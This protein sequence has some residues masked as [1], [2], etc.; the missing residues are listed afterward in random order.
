MPP[1]GPTPTHRIRDRLEGLS[2]VHGLRVRPGVILSA[3]GRLTL[4]HSLLPATL[5]DRSL[6]PGDGDL[7]ATLEAVVRRLAR[8]Q[9]RDDALGNAADRWSPPEWA[10]IAHPLTALA[11]RIRAEGTR[12]TTSIERDLVIGSCA[13]A[14]TP[15]Y[16]AV[17]ADGHSPTT[18]TMTVNVPETV[19]VMCAG[20]PLHDVVELPTCGN[21]RIDDAVQ[22][23]RCAHAERLGSSTGPNGSGP[24]RL[25]ITLR[26]ARW[27][28]PAPPP[29]D[30]SAPWNDTHP[31]HA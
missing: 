2:T 13:V 19:A 14:F 29:P 10:T 17:T 21:E 23:L 12:A 3:Q 7:D 5:R 6:D 16:L 8:I 20:R 24:P 25:V 28:A 11:I 1:A 9:M 30:R 27:I 18:V 4:D 26:P 22:G 31:H 15:T